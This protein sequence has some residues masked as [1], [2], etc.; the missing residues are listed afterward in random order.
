MATKTAIIISNKITL[1]SDY[2]QI[3]CSFTVPAKNIQKMSNQLYSSKQ[4][5]N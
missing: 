4:K 3:K 1:V 5:R 2:S